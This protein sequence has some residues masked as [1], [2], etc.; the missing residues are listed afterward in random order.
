[1]K[2]AALTGISA[3]VIKELKRGRPRTLEVQSA[4]N[5]ITVSGVDPGSHLFMTDVDRDDL[6]IGDN[7]IIVDVLSIG[8][9]MKRI[10]EFS[11]GSHFEERE[12][13]A[14][15][16]QVRYCANSSVKE[17]SPLETIQPT[18]VEVLKVTCCH[19]G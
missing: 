18:T 8:I 6:A 17:V 13:M 4:H 10:I 5:V 11:Y 2:C 15:R 7:G 19:A 9:T 14:A 16:I 12:R 1:M 3:E